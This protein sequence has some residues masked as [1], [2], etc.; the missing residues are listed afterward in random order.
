VLAVAHVGDTQFKVSE[1]DP[2]LVLPSAN[3]EITGLDIPV[4]DL[5]AMQVLDAID[6]LQPRH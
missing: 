3:D 2:V 4:D 1:V 6:E 5:V